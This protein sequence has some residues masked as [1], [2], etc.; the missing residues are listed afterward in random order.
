MARKRKKPR[1]MHEKLKIQQGA[2]DGS[3]TAMA[4]SKNDETHLRLV[5]T[6]TRE[7][8]KSLEDEQPNL[9]LGRFEIPDIDAVL[10]KYGCIS[11]KLR[12]PQ[13]LPVRDDLQDEFGA[14]RMYLLLFPEGTSIECLKKELQK[15]TGVAHIDTNALRFATTVSE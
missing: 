11:I 8:A 13:P 1:D 7:A 2:V 12:F 14:K 10:E 5:L 4:S 9:K 6:L 3:E 15:M